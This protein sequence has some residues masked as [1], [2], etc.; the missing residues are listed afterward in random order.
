MDCSNVI[1]HAPPVALSSVEFFVNVTL[2][3]FYNYSTSLWPDQIN[4]TLVSSYNSS[5]IISSG[6]W[7]IFSN[8]TSN[9]VFSF[10][11][12]DIEI[13]EFGTARFVLAIDQCQP[14]PFSVSIIPNWLSILPTILCIVLAI[15]LRQVLCAL[16][17]GTWLG[18]LFLE[19]YNPLSASLRT[20]DKYIVNSFGSHSHASIILFTFQLG[21]LIGLVQKSGGALGLS[22]IFTKFT[23]TP[24]R[25]C[26]ACFGLAVLIFFDDYSS[27]L[28]VG[29]SLRSV[30]EA[31]HVPREK[32][33][34]IVHAMGPTLASFSPVSSWIAV[35]LGCI[36]SS[37]SGS[38]ASVDPF[39]LYLETIPYRAF[40]LLMIVFVLIVIFTQRDFGPML[41]AKPHSPGFLLSD[42]DSHFIGSRPRSASSASYVPVE[43]TSPLSPHDSTPLR[44]YSTIYITSIYI[45]ICVFI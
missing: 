10:L 35:Q 14:I 27:I 40:P 7:S 38:G 12:P 24:F 33:A 37:Y 8:D 30:M 13:D 34:F 25:A 22:K 39:V 42:R 31:L 41:R 20:V 3:P 15:V 17:L 9:P 28:I 19:N 6:S 26:L 32:F 45:F 43:L 29:S 21:G 11:I 18:A 1:I 4:F 23:T 44:W 5:L 2:P 16:V 36:S